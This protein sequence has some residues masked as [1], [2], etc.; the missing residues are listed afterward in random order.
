MPGGIS[1][2][3]YLSRGIERLTGWRWETVNPPGG[4]TRIIHPASRA[5]LPDRLALLLRD[6]TVRYDHR[7]LRADG[8]WADVHST[9]TVLDRLADGS[10]EVVG[11]MADVTAER[12]AQAQAAAAGRLA[13]LG[14]MGT[15]LAHEL[16]QPLATISLAAEN[17]LRSLRRGDAAAALPRLDRITSQAQRAAGIIENLR[18]FA[19]GGDPARRPRRCRWTGRSTAPW[20]WSAGHCARPGSRWTAR[21]RSRC[22]WRSASWSRS[23]RCW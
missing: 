4:L 12:A 14:E 21:W 6:G 1:S 8:G 17:A 22:R 10:V 9:L 15:G 20:R 18:R 23:S 2:R 19:R 13:A 11:F 3:T 7:L 16:K 5:A